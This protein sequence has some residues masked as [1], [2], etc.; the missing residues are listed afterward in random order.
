MARPAYQQELDAL[1]KTRIDYEKYPNE[2]A[3]EYR[4]LHQHHLITLLNGNPQSIILTASL[5][6]DP[7]K[8]LT[9]KQLYKMLTDEQRLRELADSG[10]EG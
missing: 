4:W 5:L 1:F 8:K 7:Q 2:E 3:K 6:A 9:L 10:I